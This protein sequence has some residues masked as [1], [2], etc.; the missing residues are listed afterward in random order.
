[1]SDVAGGFDFK[2]TAERSSDLLLIRLSG[3]VDLANAPELAAHLD[4]APNSA[5]IDMA[6]VTYCGSSAAAVLVAAASRGTKITLRHVPPNVQ[7]VLD[8]TGITGMFTIEP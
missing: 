2:I 7:R 6:E 5:I 3:D 8:I 1:M 4:A